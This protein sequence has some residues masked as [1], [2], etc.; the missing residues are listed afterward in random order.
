MCIIVFIRTPFEVLHFVII[1]YMV[2]VVYLWIIIGIWYKRLRYKPVNFMFPSFAVLA[3]IQV[4][5]PFAILCRLQR[6]ATKEM[7]FPVTSWRPMIQASYLST[8]TNFV[9]SFVSGDRSPLN[10]REPPFR[11]PQIRRGY[12]VS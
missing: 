9:Q 1:H 2:N 3:K 5:V 8:T 11:C 12:P 7:I 4:Q 10:H 6:P